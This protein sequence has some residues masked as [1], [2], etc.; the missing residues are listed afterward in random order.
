MSI[1]DNLHYGYRVLEGR[2]REKI[3]AVGKALLE[4]VLNKIDFELR[5]NEKHTAAVLRDHMLR[6][7]TLF[8]SKEVKAFGLANFVVW[9]GENRTF[10]EASCKL[11]P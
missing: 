1:M 2:S 11:A 6:Q 9:M 7:A 3:A 8:G 5:T 10:P 4:N